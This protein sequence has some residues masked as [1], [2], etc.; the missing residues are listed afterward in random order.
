M[1]RKNTA[2]R[3]VRR[4]FG[5][6][7]MRFEQNSLTLEI[8][9]LGRIFNQSYTC[10][11][12]F[13]FMLCLL[14]Y[15]LS[16]ATCFGNYFA[17]MI[18]SWHRITNFDALLLNYNIHIYSSL[19]LWLAQTFGEWLLCTY[20]HTYIPTYLHTYIPWIHKS[21]EVTAGCG[22]SHNIQIY[23]YTDYRISHGY[24]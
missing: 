14:E 5:P 18:L 23:S 6:S 19:K 8:A 4:M 12:S 17:I 2:L 1:L 11:C 21:V 22:I 24:N 20:I 10:P 15:L 3:S 7:R 9:F 13:S 16:T